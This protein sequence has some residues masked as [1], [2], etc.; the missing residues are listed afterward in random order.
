LSVKKTLLPVQNLCIFL[1]ASLLATSIP[2]E[3][4]KW[5]DAEGKVHYGEKPPNTT[6]EGNI[7]TIKLR[8][9]VDTKGARKV[10]NEQSKSLDERRE[11]RKKKQTDALTAKQKLAK[12][13]ALCQ[14]AKERLVSYQ[15][16]KVTVEEDDGSMRDL[17]EEEKQ[18]EISASKKM[19]AKACNY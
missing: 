9:N 14:R 15:H 19:V 10:L 4:Y 16:P 1:F 8:D 2:A 11:N 18:S 7:E 13:K 6:T 17:G 12:N 3:I 5:V